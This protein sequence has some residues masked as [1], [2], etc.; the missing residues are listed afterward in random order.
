MLGMDG[1][2]R[3]RE[4]TMRRDGLAGIGFRGGRTRRLGRFR[5]SC[6]RIEY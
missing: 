4:E 1:I 2:S 5:S 6:V 3:G